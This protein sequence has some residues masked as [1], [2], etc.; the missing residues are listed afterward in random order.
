MGGRYARRLLDAGHAVSVWNRSPGKAQEFVAAGALLATSPAQALADADI[1]IAALENASAFRETFLTGQTL[2]YFEPR[3]LLI[4]T[5]TTH[6]RHALDAQA[7]LAPSGCGYLDAPVS[8]G[9]VGAAQGTL[10]ILV[11]GT[12]EAFERTRP[13]LQVLGHPHLLGPT[14]SGQ[15][16]KLANQTIVAVT[17]GAVAEG[18]FLAQ[19]A[20]L[21]PG[22]LLEAL[23]GGFAD[24]RVFREHGA[25]MA[26]RDFK[27]GAAN[28]IFFK[29]LAAIATLAQELG[30][31]LPLTRQ[32]TSAFRH[33]ID[34]GHAEL[35][36]SSYFHYLDA[37]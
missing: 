21:E 17:I 36:H 5:G 18:L 2:P 9:T 37:R 28:R 12:S 34:S 27:S 19:R 6:P 10:T 30:T 25:R 11:G 20:G 31:V 23:Q 22:A 24:G 16:A 15:I 32:T 26:R 8:G 3:H 29:D 13:V 14:G 7:A 4:D 1:A 33:L 35:D